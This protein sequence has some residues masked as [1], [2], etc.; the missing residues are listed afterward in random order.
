MGRVANGWKF[1]SDS[2]IPLNSDM[3]EEAYQPPTGVRHVSVT[4]ETE[5]QHRIKS[6]ITISKAEEGVC[7]CVCATFYTPPALLLHQLASV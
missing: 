6:L 2:T 7:V 4:R 5:R 1:N 3:R